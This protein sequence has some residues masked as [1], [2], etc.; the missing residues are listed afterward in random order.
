[1]YLANYRI[2]LLLIVSVPNICL[3]AS[4]ERFI[5]RIIYLQSRYPAATLLLF[6]VRVTL[7]L[8]LFVLINITKSSKAVT[9]TDVHI[10]RT[11]ANT[12]YKGNIYILNK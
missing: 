6:H 12:L 4:Y 3:V 10:M 5:Q 8:E 7:L 11:H 9:R 1:M 2:R